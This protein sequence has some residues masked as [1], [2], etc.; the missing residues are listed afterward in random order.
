MRVSKQ[1]WADYCAL[2]E[3]FKE[4]SVF[5]DY[6]FRHVRGLIP[7]PVQLDIGLTL[8][9]T[10]VDL[11]LGAQRGEGKTTIGGALVLWKLLHN[12]VATV[13]IITGKESLAASISYAALAILKTLPE[14]YMLRPK[15]R[16]GDRASNSCWDINRDYKG[17][18]KQPSVLALGVKGALQGNRF[19]L[20]IGD[21]L[22]QMAN[23][24]T[25]AGRELLL[26]LI[27]ELSNLANKGQIILFGTYQSLQSIYFELPD[28][29]YQ[30]CLYPGRFPSNRDNY[31]D[32]LAPWIIEND[33]G[34]YTYGDGTE[35]APTSPNANSEEELRN[36]PIKVGKISYALNVMLDPKLIEG[37]FSP[38][39]PNN[40]L[41]LRDD[42]GGGYPQNAIWSPTAPIKH[43]SKWKDTWKLREPIFANG[44]ATPERRIMFIDPA[45]GGVSSLNEN[46]LAEV[47]NCGNLVVCPRIM[48][49]PGGYSE[50]LL[51]EI[52]T[53]IIQ[54]GISTV[55]VEANWGEGM[56]ARLLRQVLNG[57]VSRLGLPPVLV[58]D[59]KVSNQKSKA[60]RI[61]GTLEPLI[62]LHRLAFTESALQMDENTAPSLEYSIL[63]QLE[64]MTNAGKLLQD[65]RIDALASAISLLAPGTTQEEAPPEPPTDPELDFVAQLLSQ[66]ASRT[67]INN[68]IEG[69]GLIPT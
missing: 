62:G 35:G 31:K 16:E 67:T 55:W 48:G 65:D 8:Q 46:A 15:E 39:H 5:L 43:K 49:F 58:L 30:V 50:P 44:Y 2:R 47:T 25:P 18:D 1:E 68:H 12:P 42:A 41:V 36:R 27:K 6:V 24:A 26:D 40:L 66:R 57:M 61:M 22:E 19:T 20:V 51:M 59:H 69:W 54:S 64:L 13:G 23:S 34:V 3:K 10:A 45:G 28:K 4:F 32:C 9:N 60:L 17:I 29:G 52:S 11:F 63:Q 14:F 53:V 38:L 56:W 37:N 7:D 33:P 21:D